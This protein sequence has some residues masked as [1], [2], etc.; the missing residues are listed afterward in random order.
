MSQ[1]TPCPRCGAISAE[2]AERLDLCM[3]VADGCE[4][5]FLRPPEGPPGGEPQSAVAA[6]FGGLV[7]T[8]QG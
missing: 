1:P 5:C 4:G 2:Q 8:P 6:A 3:P 7:Q